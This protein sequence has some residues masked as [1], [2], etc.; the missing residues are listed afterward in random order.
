MR[1]HANGLLKLE[2]KLRIELDEIL[3]QDKVI[4]FK[5]FRCEWISYGDQ[6]TKFLHR[7]RDYQRS[8]K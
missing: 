7:G 5:K 4:W 6:N 2:K 8:E 3:Q 1:S